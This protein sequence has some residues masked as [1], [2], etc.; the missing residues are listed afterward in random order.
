MEDGALQKFRRSEMGKKLKTI[1]IFGY[2]IGSI[3]DCESYN[4]VL[5]FF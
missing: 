1:D 3:G 4:F 5:S 2:T